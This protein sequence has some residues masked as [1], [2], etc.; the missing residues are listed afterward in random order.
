MSHTNYHG[1]GVPSS[2]EPIIEAYSNSIFN[3]ELTKP[4]VSIMGFL[5]RLDGR[6]FVATSRLP[7]A[8]SNGPFRIFSGTHAEI[9]FIKIHFCSNNDIAL[10]ELNECEVIKDFLGFPVSTQ[11]PVD[12]HILTIHYDNRSTPISPLVEC[13][14]GQLLPFTVNRHMDTYQLLW[15]TSPDWMEGTPILDEFGFVVGIL[16]GT[17]TE[18]SGDLM[19]AVPGVY[20]MEFMQRK[21]AKGRNNI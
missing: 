7:I 5:V 19:L 4:D 12:S 8:Y 18:D 10:I 3:I 21:V 2:F 9:P 17:Y 11:F 14:Y 13:R 15:L 1:Q 20:L 16:A 6:S